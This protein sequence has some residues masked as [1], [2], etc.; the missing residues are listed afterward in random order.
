MTPDDARLTRAPGSPGRARRMPSRL[1]EGPRDRER[2]PTVVVPDHDDLAVLLAD[3]VAEVIARETAAKGRCVLG[4]A[5]GS[6]P[7]GIYR[8]LIRRHQAGE[9]DFSRVV[10][11]NLDEYYPMPPD[12]PHSYRRYMWENLFAH[13]N[14]RP[15]QVHVPDGS[16]PRERL[17]EHCDAYERAIAEAGGIDLQLLGIGKSGHIG[18]NEP[19]SSQ[20]SRTSLAI[21][22][23]V[24]R[25]DAAAD[26]FGEDNVPREAITMGV[27]TILDAK[28]IALLATGEHKAG[29]VARAVEGDISTDVA[30]TF[31]QRHQSVTVYLDLPAAAELTRIKT[32]WILE[33]VDW[34]P[35]MVERSVVWLAERSGKAVLKL[36]AREYAENQLSPL[37]ARAG[38]AGPINGQ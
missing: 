3:R 18:F 5:T 33:G 30:A 17:A 32:P 6:T 31:L 26:F 24:T 22:D 27:A 21:L 16:V 34:T 36:S 14:I 4:L 20:D 10:T 2:I 23:T 38:S 25:K 28:E 29:I 1:I 11:F 8:E 12:S 7:L 9:V 13:V 35:A 19:G 37:L 15:E